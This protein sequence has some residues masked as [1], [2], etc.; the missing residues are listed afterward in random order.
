MLAEPSK[1]TS[2]TDARM[3]SQWDVEWTEANKLQS[4]VYSTG[5]TEAA[6]RGTS[7]RQ[8][9][10]LQLPRLSPDFVFLTKSCD[11]RQIMSTK[12]RGT[13]SQAV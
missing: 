6:G 3:E 9:F 13:R 7:R 4:Q 5:C 1:L 8:P 11:Q 2:T 12:T 10:W